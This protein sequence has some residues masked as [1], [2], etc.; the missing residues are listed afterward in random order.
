MMMP[1][2]F[3]SHGSP[4]V[5]IEEN[6]LGRIFLSNLAQKLPQPK[7]I[8]VISAHWDTKRPTLTS[9]PK[10]ETIHDFFGFPDELFK[11][12]Y[13]A[14]GDLDLVERIASL[15]DVD[16]SP[17][18]GLDHGAWVPLSLLYP[19]ADIPVVQLSLQSGQN[20]QYHY[21]IGSVLRPLRKEGVLILASGSVTHNLRALSRNETTPDAWAQDYEDW[22]INAI[23]N[24]DHNDLLNAKTQALHYHQAHPS[25]EHWLPLYVALGATQ[26]N[27]TLLHKG[28]EHKNLSMAAAH[29][30]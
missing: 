12:T 16:L 4:T 11:M 8:L 17:N 30:N 18:R 20:A 28:F 5:A 3:I 6:S 14:P 13:P 29:F 7:S 22:F 1:T 26:E 24:N 19:K 23:N 9:S 27:A 2:I 15:M 25:P 10:P 21:D